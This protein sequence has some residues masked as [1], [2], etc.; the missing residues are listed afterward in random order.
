MDLNTR[1]MTGLSK[2]IISSKKL[3]GKKK[4]KKECLQVFAL[5]GKGLGRLKSPESWHEAKVQQATSSINRR[6]LW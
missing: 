3:K 2:D 1:E 5:Q 4:K 6:F